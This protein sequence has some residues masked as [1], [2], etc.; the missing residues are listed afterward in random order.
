VINNTFFLVEMKIDN[1]RAI[2]LM[3]GLPLPSWHTFA[4][5]IPLLY[6]C[7]VFQVFLRQGSLLGLA[8]FEALFMYKA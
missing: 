5:G 6:Y 1:I 7:W 8:H 3:L 2:A 4:V